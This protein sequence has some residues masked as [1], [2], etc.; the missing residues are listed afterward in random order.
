LS[1]ANKID[2]LVRHC[3]TIIQ[4]EVGYFNG[5]SVSDDDEREACLKAAAKVKKYLDKKW[6]DEYGS[7]A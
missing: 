1:E 5:W 4:K 6:W 3:A 7:N 2:R